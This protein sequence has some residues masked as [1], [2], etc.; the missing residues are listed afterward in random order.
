MGSVPYTVL[1]ARSHQLETSAEDH[2][3]SCILY[4]MNMYTPIVELYVCRSECLKS[5]DLVTVPTY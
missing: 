5:T 4:S 2:N 1:E 3:Q